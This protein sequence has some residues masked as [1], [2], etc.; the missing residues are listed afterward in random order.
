MT[1]PTIQIF[2]C[3]HRKNVDWN[4][5]YIRIGNYQS[6]ASINIKDDEEISPFQMLL[7][8]CAQIWWIYKHY[9]EIGNPDYVGFC[10]YRRTFSFKIKMPIV[11]VAQNDFDFR[12]CATPSEIAYIIAQNNL[13]GISMVPMNPVNEKAHPFINIIEQ[14]K[15]LT[16]DRMNLPENIV[17][18]AFELFL[19]NSK[20]MNEYLD[21]TFAIP[22]QYLCNMFI[23]KKELFQEYSENVFKVFKVLYSEIPYEQLKSINQRFMGYIQERFTSCYLHAFQMIGKKIASIPLYT[24]DT[25]IY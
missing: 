15:Y 13:D 2:A 16:N 3:D 21:K 1:L 11:N 18:R 7:S 25:H 23:L 17:D 19:L 10:H 22:Y 20:S 4:L 6:D 8:E 12:L 14:T 24:F 9:Q 5:P